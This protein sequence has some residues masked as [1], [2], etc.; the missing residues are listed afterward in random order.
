MLDLDTSNKHLLDIK[1]PHTL[2]TNKDEQNVY[3]L[4]KQCHRLILTF[5]TRD[6]KL[7]NNQKSTSLPSPSQADKA[8][9]SDC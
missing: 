9:N 1:T 6:Y 7:T 5:L 4:C 8:D 3:T 2:S